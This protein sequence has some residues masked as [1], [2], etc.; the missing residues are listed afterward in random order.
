M[1]LALCLSQTR[2]HFPNT[3]ISTFGD[4]H[5]I[6]NRQLL[7]S[8]L[9]QEGAILHLAQPSENLLKRLQ[10]RSFLPSLPPVLHKSRHAPLVIC[11]PESVVQLWIRDME[12]R[13][14]CQITAESSLGTPLRDRLRCGPKIYSEDASTREGVVSVLT[15]KHRQKTVGGG[16]GLCSN[17]WLQDAD[18]RWIIWTHLEAPEAENLRM[19]SAQKPTIWNTH[20]STPHSTLTHTHTVPAGVCRSFLSVRPDAMK[21]WMMV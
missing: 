14:R 13:Q 4:I 19:S 6:L 2:K 12:G 5:Q 3:R 16:G 8:T 10:T 1:T 9:L 20:Q 18:R 21:W 7:L 17:I 11:R 15:D